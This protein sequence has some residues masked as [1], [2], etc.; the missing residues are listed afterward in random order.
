MGQ[1]CP[2]A[3]VP[4]TG[5]VAGFAIMMAEFMRN[6][7]VLV[8]LDVAEGWR[9]RGLGSALVGLCARELHQELPRASLWLT[10]ASRN[11]GALAFYDAL[12][13]ARTGEIPGYYRDDDALLMVHQDVE[14]LTD[15]ASGAS[16]SG[17]SP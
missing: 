8:T 6:T 13:F 11:E 10:V 7:G 3:E 12:G 15:L 9:R 5:E 16:W 4:G 1:F 17:T 14:G 2:V